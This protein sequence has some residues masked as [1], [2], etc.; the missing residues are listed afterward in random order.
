MTR[1][2]TMRTAQFAPHFLAT[3]SLALSTLL[4]ATINTGHNYAEGLFLQTS[5]PC[6]QR[7]HITPGLYLV[8]SMSS[9]KNDFPKVLVL[10]FLCSLLK[11]KQEKI[12]IYI[13]VLYM[14]L[15]ICLFFFKPVELMYLLYTSCC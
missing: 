7:C 1:N 10:T 14:I 4:L 11:D 5:S 15:D 8:G 2:S 3:S 6:Q 13:C 12:R 9:L